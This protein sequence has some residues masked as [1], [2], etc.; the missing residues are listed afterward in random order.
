MVIYLGGL[1][2]GIV[3]VGGDGDNGV[4]DGAAQVLFGGLLHLGEDH[5]GDFFGREGLTLAIANLNIDMG[6]LVLLCKLCVG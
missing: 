4:G 6:L 2:L 1:T 5:G 3:E